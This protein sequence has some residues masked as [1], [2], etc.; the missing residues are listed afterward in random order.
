MRAR[1]E[2]HLRLFEDREL[3]HKAWL[4][5]RNMDRQKYETYSDLIAQAIVDYFEV[6]KTPA[7]V[8]D[9]H[10]FC[11]LRDTVMDALART[12]PTGVLSMSD[13]QQGNQQGEAQKENADDVPADGQHEVIAEADIDW[14]FLGEE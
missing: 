5:L 14:D 1:H 10:F 13:A 2:I 8:P 7:F 6:D 4:Y 3:H 12:L 9:E 11:Q